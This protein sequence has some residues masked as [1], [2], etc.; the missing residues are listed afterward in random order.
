MLARTR[1]KWWP[2]LTPPRTTTFSLCWLVFA[3]CSFTGVVP[4][5]IA[6][7]ILLWMDRKFLWTESFDEFGESCE[8]FS[9]ESFQQCGVKNSFLKP[10]R[11]RATKCPVRVQWSSYRTGQQEACALTNHGHGFRHQLPS[12]NWTIFV[13]CE[14]GRCQPHSVKIRQTC[15]RCNDARPREYTNSKSTSV[16]FR[17]CGL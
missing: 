11:E 5:F 4:Y 17:V 8:S 6:Y 16:L 2:F 3:R 1:V 7:R 13:V 9:L 10:V 15:L 14:T 12:M